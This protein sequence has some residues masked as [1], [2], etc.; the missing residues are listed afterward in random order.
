[1]E[2][3]PDPQTMY[4]EWAATQPEFETRDLAVSSIDGL[5]NSELTLLMLG[6]YYKLILADISKGAFDTMLVGPVGTGKDG[7]VDQM[8]KLCV[9]GEVVVPCSQS[10]GKTV[11]FKNY[12]FDLHGD[13]LDIWSNH[14]VM[15]SS[16]DIELL[17]ATTGHRI[18]LREIKSIDDVATPCFTDEEVDNW[19]WNKV[20]AA[21]LMATNPSWDACEGLVWPTYSSEH[22]LERFRALVC[23]FVLHVTV[24]YVFFTQGFYPCG[25]KYD[26]KQLGT[27][28]GC[29]RIHQIHIGMVLMMLKRKESSV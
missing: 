12:L 2:R 19:R 4:E 18:M 23:C 8:E 5:G 21:R 27:A 11:V 15:T 10:S 25:S 1:M 13:R 9:P 14:I 24:S 22:E 17:K 20:L 16:M 3:Y 28:R 29:I 26:A 7:L 6:T